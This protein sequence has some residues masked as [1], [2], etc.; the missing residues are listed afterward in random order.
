[1]QG[2]QNRTRWL[3]ALAW[4]GAFG[5]SVLTTGVHA[6]SG[7]L[8]L[9]GGVT[10]IEGS[11]GGGLTPWAVI[12]G[13]GTKEQ[14]GANAF[15]TDVRSGDYELRTAGALV[16]LYDRVELSFAQQK[17]DTKAV[18]GLL[19]LGNGFTFTQKVYGAKIKLAGD[20]VLE[21][22]SRACEHS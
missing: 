1:M 13:Y 6:E 8:L 7:K 17:F 10:N 11:G 18:G 22:D 16:G 9:T 21:Q 14:V 5:G 3:C 19:G 2:T 20:A 15:F 12:G 4:I